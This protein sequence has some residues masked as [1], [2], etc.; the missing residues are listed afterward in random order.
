VISEQIKIRNFGAIKEFDLDL[1][2]DFVVS[3]LRKK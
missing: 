3:N 2:K 1:K